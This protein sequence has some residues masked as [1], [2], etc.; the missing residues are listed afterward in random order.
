MCVYMYIAV[1]LLFNIFTVSPQPEREIR[2]Q[3]ERYTGGS[4]ART[5]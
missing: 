1:Y 2:E 5:R 3:E 4:A